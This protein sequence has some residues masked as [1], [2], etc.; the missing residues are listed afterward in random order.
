MKKSSATPDSGRSEAGAG[1]RHLSSRGHSALCGSRR[2]MR[3][4]T[5]ANPHA[6]TAFA[7]HVVR[8]PERC[9]R[10]ERP[11]RPESARLTHRFP[12]FTFATA[13]LHFAL[14]HEIVCR[15][16]AGRD[17]GGISSAVGALRPAV[18]PRGGGHWITTSVHPAAVTLHI[19]PSP[20]SP[21]GRRR[22]FWPVSPLRFDPAR[23]LRALKDVRRRSAGIV[24]GG[25]PS[26]RDRTRR[27]ETERLPGH[28]PRASF[29]H[30]RF[31]ANIR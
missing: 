29:I 18:L 24:G 9:R 13:C 27:R 21:V 1:C 22:V 23:A 20:L 17:G 12:Q 11:E 7:Q 14:L 4:H 5:G 15:R 30:R 25:P 8:P 16:G 3:P 19:S 6:G 10:P 26:P 2:S 31:P 28:G